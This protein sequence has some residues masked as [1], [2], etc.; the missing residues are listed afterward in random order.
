[1][2][3]IRSRRARRTSVRRNPLRGGPTQALIFSSGSRP[4]Q[5]ALPAHP[6]LLPA[7]LCNVVG[8]RPMALS[9]FHRLGKEP[10]AVSRRH[11]SLRQQHPEVLEQC[12]VRVR[13][14]HRCILARSR[15]V[16]RRVETAVRMA[17]AESE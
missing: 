5:E 10:G 17:E 15:A 6:A 9:E 3:S 16:G 13:G 2:T 11:V 14:R 12:E 8:S 7:A 4:P 1:M